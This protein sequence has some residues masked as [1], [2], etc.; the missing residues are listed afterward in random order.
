MTTQLTTAGQT[1]PERTV[2]FSKGSYGNKATTRIEWGGSKIIEITTSKRHNGVISCQAMVAN[3]SKDGSMMT[4]DV[5]GGWS[6]T[7]AHEHAT[8]TEKT[9][10]RVHSAGLAAFDAL[11]SDQK[12]ERAE[13]EPQIEIGQVLF[14]HGYGNERRRAVYEIQEGTFGA[15]LLTVELD[16]GRTHIDDHV[17]HFSKKFGIGTYWNTGDVISP[18]LLPELV[19]KAKA[20]MAAEYEAKKAEEEAERLRKEKQV[21]DGRAIVQ[22]SIGDKLPPYAIIGK[23]TSTRFNMDDTHDK[24]VVKTVILGWSHHKSNV[25]SE[26]IAAAQNFEETK[27]LT[28][29]DRDTRTYSSRVF[30]G[31]DWN[32]WSVY[33]T[34]TDNENYIYAVAQQGYYAKPM[35]APSESSETSS[36]G[37]RIVHNKQQDGIEIHFSAKP[38][39]GTLDTIKA[40]GF[41][42]SKFNKCWYK[43]DSEGARRVAANYGALPDS[44]TTESSSGD[45][46]DNMIIDQISDRIGA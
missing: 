14:T 3:A 18:E 26:L 5:F 15:K 6:K 9:I 35:T 38:S 42:W 13:A 7:L 19:A 4:F 17:K 12:P 2:K 41:R 29:E 16:G 44:L 30:V 23:L 1:A 33:K 22:N 21:E 11:P 24:D 36:A 10:L 34:E 25:V 37:V 27:H 8:A 46:F 31:S 45:D 40:A 43:R 32:G 28:A 20:N 39:Q